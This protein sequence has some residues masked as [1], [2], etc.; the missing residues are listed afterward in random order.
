[1]NKEKIRN[2]NKKKIRNQKNFIV[3]FFIC[4]D[5][6]ETMGFDTTNVTDDV[7]KKI[8][9]KIPE[10]AAESIYFHMK[11]VAETLNIPKKTK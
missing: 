11:H 7:M 8:A 9:D 6:L 10:Y 2:M 5:E 4:R 1:M 3:I